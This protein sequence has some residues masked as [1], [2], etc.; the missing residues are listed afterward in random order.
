MSTI[1]VQ[2]TV[3]EVVARHPQLSRIV[4]SLK[5]D[6]CCGG[7][8]TIREAC[9]AQDLDPENIAAMLSEYVSSGFSKVLPNPASMSLVELADHVEQTHHV[10]LKEELPRLDELTDKV[11]RKYG[12]HDARL[13]RVREVLIAMSNELFSHMLKEEQVLF[14]FIRRLERNEG[15]PDFFTAARSPIPFVKWK[16]STMTLTHRS[17]VW[18]RRFQRHCVAAS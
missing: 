13:H 8:R 7:G 10:Y 14:P 16:Q 15:P 17:I 6:Y 3:G 4:E 9:W 1:D 18:R 12:E 5:I 11:V 2:Q